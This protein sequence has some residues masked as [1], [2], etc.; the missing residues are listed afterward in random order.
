M[1]KVD[2]TPTEL[3][4]QENTVVGSASNS[5]K[6]ETDAAYQEEHFNADEEHA[7]HPLAMLSPARKNFLLF[8]FSI[9]QFIDGKFPVRFDKIISSEILTHA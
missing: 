6:L 8:I 5:L 4:M 1:S 9:A 2:L 7:Q 3:E